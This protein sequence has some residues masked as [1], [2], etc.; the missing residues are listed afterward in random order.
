MSWFRWLAAAI[1]RQ[2]HA[3]SARA[4]PLGLTLICGASSLPDAA[5]T[6]RGTSGSRRGLQ[7]R[8]RMFHSMPSP[9][10]PLPA[11]ATFEDKQKWK[12]SG[13]SVGPI[14]PRARVP[15]VLTPSKLG[16]DAHSRGSLETS[17]DCPQLTPASTTP[18]PSRDQ[19]LSA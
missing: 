14:W 15:G 3:V 2:R 1:C 16:D 12:E 7:P 5:T 19:L 9:S 11:T 8:L 10:Q 6:M 17:D 18:S 4:T 13:R